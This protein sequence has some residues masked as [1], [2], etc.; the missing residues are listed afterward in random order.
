MSVREVWYGVVT[1]QGSPEEG[2]LRVADHPFFRGF[3]RDFVGA[4]EEGSVDTTYEPGELIVREGEVADHF[5]LI[6]HGKVALE[7]SGPDWVRRTV[8]TVGG[9][10]VLGWS[11]VSSPYLWQFDGRALK[12]TRVVSL[13]ASVL[14]NAL[15]GRPA[16][17]YRF[18]LRLL[19]V[20]GHRLENTRAQLLELRGT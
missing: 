15:E 9:G 11:W 2:R 18:L 19:P 8:Q 5:H 10:E 6:Y 3:D 1:A 20:I 17:G 7:V 16:E 14:R 4:I 13:E 12:E